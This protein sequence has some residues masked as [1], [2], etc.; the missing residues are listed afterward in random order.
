M[1]KM[2]GDW[3]MQTEWLFAQIIYEDELEH[4]GPLALNL[5]IVEP[6]HKDIMLEEAYEQIKDIACPWTI[7][8][9]GETKDSNRK[10]PVRI[11]ELVQH[12]MRLQYPAVKVSAISD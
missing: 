8:R 5:G 6:K 12:D 2:V 3:C 11:P 10:P 7:R 9:W 4:H 1:H